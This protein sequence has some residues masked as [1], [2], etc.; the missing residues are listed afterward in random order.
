MPINDL[1]LTLHPSPDDRDLEAGFAAAVH[2]P[3]WFLARQWQMG[4]HQGEN[5]STP[6][7]VEYQLRQRGIPPSVSASQLDPTVVAAEAIVETEVDDWWTM[8]RRIRVG[9]LLRDRVPA[10]GDARR[11]F[12]FRSAPPPY[13]CFDDQPDGL[14]LW[15]HRVR[16]SIEVAAFGADRPPDGVSFAWN[17]QRLEYNRGFPTEVA[18][19]NVTQHRGGAVDWFSADA[20]G[21]APL[22][23]DPVEARSVLPVPLEYPGAPANRFWQIERED[24]DIGGYAPDR[25]HFPTMLLIDLIYSHSDDWFMIPVAAKAGYLTWLEEL[26][27]IDS[28]DQVYHG[29]DPAFQRGL[30]PPENWRL[31]HTRG[32]A[33]NQL[34]MWIVAETPL[35]STVFEKVD[36]GVDEASNCVWAVE[37]M[38][39]GCEAHSV[40]PLQIP[41]AGQTPTT[42]P[43]AGDMAGLRRWRYE[44]SDTPQPFWHPYVYNQATHLLEQYGLAD[45]SRTPPV[46]MPHPEAEVLRDRLPAGGENIHCLNPARVPS[47]GL[48]VERSWLLARDL[49]GQPRLWIQRQ[50]Q[51]L[52]SPPGRRL[53]FDIAVDASGDQQ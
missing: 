35:R 51:P 12:L 17:S 50:C 13:D 44:P 18:G 41:E 46:P 3:W 42:P 11:A 2:D 27:V 8:G 39:D 14:A 4:E 48:S 47:N 22:A 21:I 36:L 16:L 40:P 37:R 20:V 53:R 19:L 34:L 45:F 9:N 43:A 52:L 10:D 38:L 32:L 25:A 29:G 26:R 1:Y 49:D 5:A 31:F 28:F 15:R 33:S 6:V 7:R 30:T 24:V 23:S